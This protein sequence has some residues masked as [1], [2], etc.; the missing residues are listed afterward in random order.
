[1]QQ[2]KTYALSRGSY[3]E[4]QPRESAFESQ[5]KILL[6]PDHLC[7]MEFHAIDT[8]RDSNLLDSIRE[9][10]ET[11]E[12]AQDILNHMIP[13]R[14]SCSQSQKPHQDYDKFSSHDG[15]LF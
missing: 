1:M 2:G 14:A 5:K 6:G 4:L 8:P 15:L 10:I 12:F 9:H 13:D 11:D 7:P 3:M